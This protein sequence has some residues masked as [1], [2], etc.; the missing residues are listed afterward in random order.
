M[1][2]E[3]REYGDRIVLYVLKSHLTLFTRLE[4]TRPVGRGAKHETVKD[5]GLSYET[6]RER[7]K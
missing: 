2:R 1:G 5:Q 3:G 6:N 7:V 4:Y